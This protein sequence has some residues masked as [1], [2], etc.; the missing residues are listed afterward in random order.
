MISFIIPGPFPPRKEDFPSYLFSG[1]KSGALSG[2][3][4]GKK[5]SQSFAARRRQ[6]RLKIPFFP[7]TQGEL[8]RNRA[9]SGVQS[10]SKN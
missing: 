1:R 5:A 6:K 3:P 2:A 7:R 9:L 10:H 8:P 4:L